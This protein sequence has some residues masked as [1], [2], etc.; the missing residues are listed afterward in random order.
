MW[1]WQKHVVFVKKSI[2]SSEHHNSRPAQGS[3]L[4]LF[5]LPA[6][7]GHWTLWQPAAYHAGTVDGGNLLQRFR[8]LMIVSVQRIRPAHH[9]CFL[10]ADSMTESNG[11]P[12]I[13]DV[14]VLFNRFDSDKSGDLSR[15]GLHRCIFSLI[16]L[17]CCRN[18]PVCGC[19][20][21]QPVRLESDGNGWS[22]ELFAMTAN[23]IDLA[24]VCRC[25]PGL[26]HDARSIHRAGLGACS[27]HFQQVVS[28]R[29]VF[30][31]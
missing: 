6:K 12:W 19:H 17:L 30:G 20:W 24:A 5:H 7:L 25:Q 27:R 8:R 26:K 22:A 16:H 1:F 3:L 13:E 31:H 29:L 2:F 10:L 4:T 18:G 23:L 14:K 9:W 11:L 21:F 15:S 28:L